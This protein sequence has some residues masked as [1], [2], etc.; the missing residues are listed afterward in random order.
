LALLLRKRLEPDIVTWVN[1]AR[2]VGA[3]LDA[4]D[5][6]A[7]DEM[8]MEVDREEGMS[9]LK[10]ADWAELWDWA[11]PA[12]N[13]IARKVLLEPEEDEE[14][15]EE[16]EDEEEQDG[17]EQSG[18][19]GVDTPQKPQMPPEIPMMKLDD[20]LKFSSTGATPRGMKAGGA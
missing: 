2:S 15:E 4:V 20:I 8:A 1:D 12:A 16:E 11:A 5:A 6:E 19:E 10:S 18:K 7:A 14:E 9:Q 13:Q 3:K 17:D